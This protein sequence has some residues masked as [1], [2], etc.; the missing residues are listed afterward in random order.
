MMA[1]RWRDPAPVLADRAAVPV[2]VDCHLSDC[3][4]LDVLDQR[5]AEV[6]HERC[7]IRRRLPGGEI[8]L[9]CH[10]ECQD[11]SR[12]IEMTFPVLGFDFGNLPLGSRF[13]AGFERTPEPRAPLRWANSSAVMPA[14][15]TTEKLE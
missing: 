4:R 7:D 10:F 5:L 14:P 15:V 12:T 3:A 9:R 11:C 2:Q 1:L 6:L 8:F 13:V